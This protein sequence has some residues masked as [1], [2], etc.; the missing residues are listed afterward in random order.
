MEE[1]DSLECKKLWVPLFIFEY[2]FLEKGRSRIFD[3]LKNEKG[4]FG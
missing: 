1:I 2:I 3:V 4:N